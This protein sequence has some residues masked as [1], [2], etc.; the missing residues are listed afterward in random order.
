MRS[1]A[2]ILVL[3]MLVA[4]AAPA[5]L[6]AAAAAAATK[7]NFV[8]FIAD[9]LSWHDVS[10]YG[11]TDVRTPNVERL[12]RESL[13]FDRAFAASPTCTPSRSSLFC[14]LYPMRSGAHANHSM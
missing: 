3:L 11:A 7:P 4:A 2:L 13:K 12:A 8:L 14:G 10:A 9:D 6:R 5:T 1:R